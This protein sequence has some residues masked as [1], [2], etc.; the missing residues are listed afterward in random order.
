LGKFA[1]PKVEDREVRVIGNQFDLFEAAFE[2]W[3]EG[4]SFDLA[5]DEG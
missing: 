2:R 1:I 3:K 4:V 5:L